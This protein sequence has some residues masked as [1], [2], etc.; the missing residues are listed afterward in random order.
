[1]IFAM[2]NI[3]IP[4]VIYIDIY[5]YIYGILLE[6]KMITRDKILLLMGIKCYLWE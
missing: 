2:S 6:A 5:I 1:M 4:Q 3:Y